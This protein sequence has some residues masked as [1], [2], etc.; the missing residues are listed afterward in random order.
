[1]DR[2]L[3]FDEYTEL[4]EAKRNYPKNEFIK[5]VAKLGWNFKQKTK[6]QQ[7]WKDIVK[8]DGTNGTI[9]LHTHIHNNERGNCIDP[10]TIQFMVYCLKKEYSDTGNMEF[11]ENA[12]WKRW[13]EKMP[14]K[15]ELDN[16]LNFQSPPEFDEESEKE[17]I[18]WA[19]NRWN[20]VDFM[21]LSNY[22]Y[23][24]DKDTLVIKKNE[25]GVV[26]Y[27]TCAG[28][29]DRRPLN[30]MWFDEIYT[31]EKS[32]KIPTGFGFAVYPKTKKEMEKRL[33]RVY[34]VDKTGTTN[35]DWYFDEP[36]N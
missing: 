31:S 16:P 10:H 30:Y 13:G 6:G 1:M 26:K 32:S 5:D 24:A 34:P 2:I 15:Q 36:N 18:A 23:G 28:I 14:T 20:K 29:N 22:I 19:N 35:P 33:F 25:R 7:F 11:I 8:K 27:N 9:V 3:L 21:S 17:N 12:P 4:N